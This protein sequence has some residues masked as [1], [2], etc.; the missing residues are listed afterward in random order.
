ME[1]PSLTMGVV[2]NWVGVGELVGGGV[3]VGRRV[4]V[5]VVVFVTVAE[6]AGRAIRVEV[7]GSDTVEEGEVVMVG[8][9]DVTVQAGS[10]TTLATQ[11]RNKIVRARKR[12]FIVKSRFFLG[13]F[14][15]SLSGMGDAE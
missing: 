2:T 11:V 15:S 1:V 5:G 10:I 4:E 12:V 7:E 9:G 6:A 3:K 14:D 8:T 13:L